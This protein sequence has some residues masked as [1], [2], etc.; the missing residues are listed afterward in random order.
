MT[1]KLT[2]KQQKALEALIVSSSLRQAARIS[3]V[4]ERAIQNYLKQNE[5][6][7]AYRNAGA[8]RLRNAT[9]IMQNALSDAASALHDIVKN[10][11]EPSSNRI[12]AA[13][14]LLEYGARYTEFTDIL[15]EITEE[16]NNEA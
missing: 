4:S 3:G 10:G 6:L 2:A 12:A 1:D 13:R 9:R 5:F 14:A 7:I 11:N 16:R 8:A 15:E